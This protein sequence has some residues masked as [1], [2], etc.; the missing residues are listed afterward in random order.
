MLKNLVELER[1][2]MYF[3]Y[4]SH[5]KNSGYIISL[6]I[7]SEKYPDS[8]YVKGLLLYEAAETDYV[9]R[10]VETSQQRP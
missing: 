6:I 3:F 2:Y 4:L 5:Y 7:Q 9:T 1:V 8:W 10:Q